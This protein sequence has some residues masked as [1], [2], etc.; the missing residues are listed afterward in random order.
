MIY[1]VTAREVGRVKIGFSD[2]PRS[3]FVKMRTDSPI[4]LALER[5]C[6]GSLDDERELHA[7]FQLDRVSGEWF[8]LSPDIEEHMAT[9]PTAVKPEREKSLASKIISA[10]G[11]S[12]SYA[13]MVASGVREAPWSLAVAVYRATG[14]KLSR[15]AHLNDEQIDVLETIERWEPP[16]SRKRGAA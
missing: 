2:E 5:I 1:F 13:S 4:A 9:L 6:E 12:P 7:R 3:R 16:V 15:I 8:M 11:V 10:T 14:E